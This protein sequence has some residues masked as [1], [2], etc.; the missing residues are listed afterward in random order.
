MQFPLGPGRPSPPPAPV[1]PRAPTTPRPRATCRREPPGISAICQYERD[2]SNKEVTVLQSAMMACF[3]KFEG[4]HRRLTPPPISRP[5]SL[6]CP[7]N[8]A[9]NSADSVPQALQAIRRGLESH[10]GYRVARLGRRRWDTMC[11]NAERL[12]ALPMAACPGQ[13]QR[14]NFSGRRTS[15]SAM[16]RIMA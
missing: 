8:S 1:I 13:Q 16:K 7:Q 10:S 6:P 4:Q 2:S 9:S 14:Q 5:Q 3:H 11:W 15:T 12:L